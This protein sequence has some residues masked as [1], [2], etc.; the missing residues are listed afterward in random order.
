MRMVIAGGGTGGHIF[1][2]LAV[3][4]ELKR[5]DPEGEVMF[6]GT[7]RGIEAR[8]IPREGF[9]IQFIRAE[10]VLGRSL[11]GKLSAMLGVGLSV[12]GAREI[13]RNVRPDIVLGTGG[14]VSVPPVVAAWSMA[15]PTLI[16]EQNLMPGL[17]NRFLGRLASGVAITYHDSA[18]FFRRDRTRLTGNPVRQAIL[19][20]RRDAALRLFEL[21]EG[22]FT[23]FIMG[24]SLG[25][26]S[27]NAAIAGALGTLADLKDDIQF[28]HQS[29]EA[30]YNMV[31]SAYRQ[32]GF[33]AMVAPFIYKMAEAYA[34]ADLVVARA[35]ASTL[36]ELTALGKPSVLVPYP[37]A[38][39][40]QELNAKKLL[41]AEAC[42]VI[43]DSRL[44]G[45]SLGAVIR[46]IASSEEARAEMVRNAKS[47]GR[48]DAA[49]RV[50]DMAVALV[51]GRHG[52]V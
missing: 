35:G 21:A 11:A 12:F 52:N 42:R 1:P 6:I 7:E 20:G 5:R 30:D 19:K 29:G 47:L 41:E 44:D 23:V 17:A 27:I 10:G 22:R 26:R 33:K 49:A 14:Y 2:G 34:V 37:H 16:M 48:P 25:A 38:S 8:V 40:H 36:A 50:V 24:G 9:P 15:I 13:L 43:W 32:F 31:R 39:G 46:E 45:P 4:E 18:G 51:R 28:L 3:A